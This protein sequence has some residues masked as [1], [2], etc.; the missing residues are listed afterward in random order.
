MMMNELLILHG[1]KPAGTCNCDGFRTHK[2]NRDEYQVRWRKG[3]YKF[4]VRKNGMRLTNWKPVTEA[5][6]V[7]DMIHPQANIY[8]TPKQPEYVAPKKEKPRK[9][10]PAEQKE[11][12]TDRGEI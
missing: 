2:Y 8:I 3:G 5:A 9:T 6:E 4:M 7:F 11:V 10:N 1:Y 12:G